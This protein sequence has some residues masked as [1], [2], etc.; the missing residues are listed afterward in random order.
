MTGQEYEKMRSPFHKYSCHTIFLPEFFRRDWKQLALT[1]LVYKLAAFVLLTPLVGILFRVLLAGSG[2]TVLADQDILFYFLGPA[3]W[4]CSIVVGGVWLGIVALEQAALMAVL[5]ASQT[6]RRI[7]LLAALRFAGANAWPVLR[8]TARMVGFT[9]LTMAP[10]LTAAGIAYLTLLGE[11]DI[12]YYLREKPPVFLVALGIGG[13]LA[14]ALVAVL[15]RLFTGWFFAIPLVL[16]EDVRPARALRASNERSR[17][18]RRKLLS[19]IVGWALASTVLSAIATSVVIGA[20]H[21]FVPRSRDPWRSC[22]SRSAR[23]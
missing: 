7:H 17:G 16:F 13:L 9:L 2:N 22:H 23:R 12:N 10:F 15:L 18:R 11:Y 6:Q 3:G 5:C 20:G 1:D 19:W 4:L 21:F 8:V 14:V